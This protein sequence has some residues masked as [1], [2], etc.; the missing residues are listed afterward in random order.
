MKKFFALLTAIMCVSITSY[1]YSDIYDSKEKEKI[2][3]LSS[4]NIINGYEDG[5]FR[6]QN[7]IT[8]AEF[9]KIVTVAM[10]LENIIPSGEESFEDVSEDSWYKDYVYISKVLGIINGMSD[11]IFAPNENITYEQ[12]IKMLV[13]ALGYNEEAQNKGGY[14][15]GYIQV[16]EELGITKDMQ[17]VNTRYA[18]RTDIATMIYNGL[19]SKCYYLV[20]DGEKVERMEADSTLYE[21]HKAT[22]EIG[23]AMENEENTENEDIDNELSG[24]TEE[25]EENSVG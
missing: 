16:A 15:N 21:L 17:F 8:R 22:L 5:S 12:A 23:E 24:K 6:P 2:E 11:T 20:F 18:T 14:P 19:Y 25:N 13:V 9:A 10:R 1:A 3:V 7:S 4:F